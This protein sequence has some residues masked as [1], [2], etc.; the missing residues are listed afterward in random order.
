MKCEY[1]RRSSTRTSARIMKHSWMR[2]RARS[3]K[4]TSRAIIRRNVTPCTALDRDLRRSHPSS[5][6]ACITSNLIKSSVT[7]LL[8]AAET[9]FLNWLS[10]YL[11]ARTSLFHRL[12]ISVPSLPGLI[13]LQLPCNLRSSLQLAQLIRSCP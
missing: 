1:W 6:K 12:D 7:D 5:V 2:A 10:S 8:K 9:A 11:N 4:C 13:Q 3:G